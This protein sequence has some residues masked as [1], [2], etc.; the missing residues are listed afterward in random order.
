[1]FELL[2]EM[3]DGGTEGVREERKEDARKD[4]Q[5]PE[6]LQACKGTTGVLDCSRN[7]I[8]VKLPI[9][10]EREKESV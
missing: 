1:M 2:E 4:S 7:V 3:R 6:F 5:L 9:D 10:R 8:V